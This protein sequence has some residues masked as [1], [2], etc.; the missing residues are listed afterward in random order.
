MTTAELKNRTVRDLAS[1]AKKKKVPGWHSM[2]KDELVKALLRQARAERHR[3][4]RT[5]GRDKRSVP[6]SLKSRRLA[7]VQ[8]RLAEAKDLTFRSICEGNGQ[9]KD[10]LIV[11]V[12]DSYWL[13]AY[14]ELSRKSIERAKVALGQY[15]HGA[16]PVL[17]VCEVLREGVTTSTRQPIRDIEIHGGVH[18]WYIDV[19]NPP[20]NYQLDIG[21]LTSEG[22]F[23]CVARS[24]V[25]TTPPA[26]AGDAFDQNWADVA[27][28]FDRIFALSGGYSQPESNSDL[29]ELFEERLQR[30][31][32][33]PVTVQFGPGA[34]GH[35]ANCSDFEFQV[36]T[37]LIVHGVTR[38]DAHVTLRGEPVRLRSDG[39]FAVRFNL[40][41]RRHVL[42]MVASSRDGA[43]QRTIVLA[44]D[45]NTK[46]M[47]PISH[48]PTV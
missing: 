40:P 11:M 17:R 5:N 21:Y 38:P 6:H 42:P 45:R 12:R 23:F 19:G 44:V 20:K 2:R 1:M 43:E 33:D 29:K 47:E 4:E 8:T 15:W 31:I 3:S 46:V 10:R 37:E 30:P 32:G 22:K 26:A 35:S 14:W 27:K 16:R 36:D 13:H 9:V 39:S 18:N 28:D 34:A 24:N 48:D 7:Q 41:N 25:V